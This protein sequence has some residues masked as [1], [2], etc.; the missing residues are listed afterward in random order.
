MT[1]TPV[2]HVE[3]HPQRRFTVVRRV[4]PLPGEP[5]WAVALD[6]YRAEVVALFYNSTDA[7]DYAEWRTKSK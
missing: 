4:P 3:N 5:E 2:H 1:R 7:N 6:G